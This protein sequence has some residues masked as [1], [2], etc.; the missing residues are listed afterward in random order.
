MD[1][2]IALARRGASVDTDT[3]EPDTAKWLPYYL[4]HGGPPGR[5]T[6]SSDAHT[7]GGSPE[8]LFH[9]FKDAVL[10]HG[11]PPER[12]V[13]TPAAAGPQYTPQPAGEVG[14]HRPFVWRAIAAA[15]GRPSG[16]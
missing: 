10:G 8:K 3:V 14:G 7:P 2:A 13:V 15:H 9:T 16:R 1:E 4:E 12:V 5:F 6:F 11:L